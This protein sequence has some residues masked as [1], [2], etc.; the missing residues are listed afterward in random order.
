MDAFLGA[1]LLAVEASDSLRLPRPERTDGARSRTGAATSWEGR[2]GSRVGGSAVG[3]SPGAGDRAT[4]AGADGGRPTSA[5]P[6][7]PPRYQAG[8]VTSAWLGLTTLFAV[9]EPG[10][11]ASLGARASH[12][13]PMAAAEGHRPPVVLDVPR[14]RRSCSPSGRRPGGLVT[15]RGTAQFSRRRATKNL[16]PASVRWP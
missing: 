1:L 16:A 7:E 12:R 9:V 11:R 4:P 13:D 10:A 14:A 6:R 8:E 5:R 15:R 2:T 3:R